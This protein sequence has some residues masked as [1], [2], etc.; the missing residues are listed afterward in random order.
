MPDIPS[1]SGAPQSNRLPRATAARPPG[2]HIQDRPAL[3]MSTM[4]RPVPGQM[5][6][7]PPSL[8]ARLRGSRAPQDP[9][10]TRL[11]SSHLVISYAVVCVEKQRTDLYLSLHIS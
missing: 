2:S 6:E 11:N 5:L 3:V 8:L 10:S 4:V 9:K 1:W 7:L